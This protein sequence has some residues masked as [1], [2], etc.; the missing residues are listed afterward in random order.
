MD[1]AIKRIEQ[2]DPAFWQE[3]GM[4]LAHPLVKGLHPGA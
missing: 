1:N 2:A 4:K 3:E